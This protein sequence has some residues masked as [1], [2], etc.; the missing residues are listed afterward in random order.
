MDTV[1]PGETDTLYHKDPKG[2]SHTSCA[3]QSATPFHKYVTR[4]TT[5]LM[6]SEH[7]APK[8]P[9]KYKI[10]HIDRPLYLQTIE[11]RMSKFKILHKYQQIRELPWNHTSIL[12]Q[13]N[14]RRTLVFCAQMLWK[15]SH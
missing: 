13:T 6:E 1:I 4:K 14:T 7:K 11:C 8:K 12:P 5:I 3:K 2:Q 15:C 9:S 10:Y